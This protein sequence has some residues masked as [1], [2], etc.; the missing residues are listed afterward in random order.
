MRIWLAF[1]TVLFTFWGFGSP[2][3]Q[4]ADLVVSGVITN[5][6]EVTA[7]V[8][9]SAY[10]QLVKL[11]G[12]ELKGYTDAQGLSFFVSDWPK[13]SPRADGSFKVTLKDL[14][15]GDYFIA[16]QRAA[17]RSVP[18]STVLTGTPIL[19]KEDGNPLIIKVPSSSPLNVGKVVVAV[20][21]ESSSPSR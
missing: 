1:L 17:P 7:R 10:L 21:A 14:S 5:W 9:P 19:V 15:P 13:I 12:K 8:P 11:E 20:K 16:L 3:V 6:K 18:G 2:V 4:A